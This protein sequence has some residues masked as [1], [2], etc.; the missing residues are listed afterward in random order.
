MRRCLIILLVLTVLVIPAACGPPAAPPRAALEASSPASTA[1]AA[2]LTPASPS[3]QLPTASSPPAPSVL[4]SRADLHGDIVIDGSSTV[5]PLTEAAAR[6]FSAIAPRV[7]IRLGVS[8]TGGGFKKF[9]AGETVISNA[10]RPI[11]QSEQAQCEENGISFIELPV[12]F[13]GISVVVN[14]S[15][16]W[17]ACMT[18]AELKRLWEPAAEST[19]MRWQQLRA[20]WPDAPISLYGPGVDSGTHDYFTAAIVGEEGA[21]R[22]DYT[23][24]EDDYVL[25]QNVANNANAL[26]YFGYAYYREYQD[27]LKLVAID[28]GQGCTLPSAETI[29]YGRYQPLSRPI[30]IYVRAAALE[31]PELRAFVDFYLANAGRLTNDVRYVPL[32]ARAYVLVTQR[33]AQHKTGSVFNGGS[34]IGVSIEDILLLEGE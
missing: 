27:K 20:D 30:F 17:A 5:F 22:S 31:R 24:S 34:Q 6:E 26:G 7:Q 29:T 28:N 32:P 8:G 10:S 15:N 25:A 33:V 13:D 14:P 16:D 1:P 19:V 9:C 23:A 18:V 4:P 11:K 2:P 12:A 3:P 21:N